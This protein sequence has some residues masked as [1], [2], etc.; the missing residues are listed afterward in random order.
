MQIHEL[1]NYNGDINSDSFV[2]VDNGLDTGK[3]SVPNLLQSVTDLVNEANARIDN[4]IAGGAAPSEA[5]IIDARLGSDGIDYASLGAAI[6][7]QT[8]LLNDAVFNSKQLLDKT[9]HSGTNSAATFNSDGTITFSVNDYGNTFIGGNITLKKG[10]YS[11]FGVPNGMSFVST[12]ESHTTAFVT[13]SSVNALAF[14]VTSETS[15]YVGFRIESNPTSPFTINPELYYLDNS[16]VK[17]N[18]EN[19]FAANNSIAE[20]EAEVYKQSDNLFDYYSL[21]SNKVPGTLGSGVNSFVDL[22]DWYTSNLIPVNPGKQ[23]ALV[24]NGAV[25]PYATLRI[26]G[27]SNGVMI[28]KTPSGTESNPITIP[29]GVDHIR[30]FTSS[31][32][33]F[34]EDNLTSFKKYGPDM[35]L[36]CR[37]F[38]SLPNAVTFDDVK[39]FGIYVDGS[40]YYH[41]VRFGEKALIRLFKREG[42]NN[43]FQFSALYVG[44]VS[45]QGVSIESTIAIN[46]TDTVGPISILRQ[47][48]DGGGEFSGGWHTVTVDGVVC[49]TAEQ[50][51]LDLK[52][53]GKSIIG[54]NGL[55][56]GECIATAI[57][58]LY[59][60]QTV[61]GTDL[62]GATQ[63]IEETVIYTLNDKMSARV[64]H[65]YKADTR[66]IL[67]YG[68]QA[69][70]IGFD[71]ILLPDNEKFLNFSDMSSDLTLP[72]AE[73]L[74][75]LKNSDW[76]YD[77][78]I[79][80][81]GLAKYE[82][83]GGTRY[84]V[85]PKNTKKVYWILMDGSYEYTFITSG[86][87]LSWEGT[88]NIYPN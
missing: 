84:G 29:D 49:P 27:Y 8:G 72:K 25:S 2:A 77:L 67:Y 74:M 17:Q 54:E 12:T 45:D 40:N 5:E 76:T 52:I 56:Y 26:A 28:Y 66:V 78:S 35:D 41:F 83:N 75:S 88:W 82:H 62:S 86:T 48:V 23:Y 50:E 57:N 63:A 46:G 30:F 55:H 42:G 51:R 73:S 68:L 43:L 37:P 32:F 53:N 9:I 36:I 44:D 70:R 22:S 21:I 11:L 24:Y 31:S 1:N 15:C 19:I 6:R 60:P 59:F 14:D 33:L 81:F 16:L 39:T 13:N 58:K 7:T 71:S 85:L 64:I 4:I 61:T 38:G 20:I 3:I 34:T 10:R 69:V 80:G 79:K 18:T 87:V 47:G 65:N